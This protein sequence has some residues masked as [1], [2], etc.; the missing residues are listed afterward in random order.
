MMHATDGSSPRTGLA[1]AYPRPIEIFLQTL[2]VLYEP[3][4]FELRHR[5]LLGTSIHFDVVLRDRANV[6]LLML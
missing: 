3:S 1:H 6:C 5:L 4:V 2:I